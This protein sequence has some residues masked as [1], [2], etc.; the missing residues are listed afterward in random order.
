MTQTELPPRDLAMSL[1]AVYAC[2]FAN[3]LGMGL[4]LPLFSLLLERNGRLQRRFPANARA[5]WLE[6]H[7]TPEGEITVDDGAAKAL[8]GGASLLAVG[9]RAVTGPFERGAAVAIRD[10][11]GRTIAKGVTAY[12][13]ADIQRIAGRRTEEAEALLGYR[14]RPAIIHRDDM[15]RL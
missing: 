15:V 5:A 7:L 8:A 3:G 12:S 10:A 11:S 1:G 14:G 9:V 6:G 13:S 4:S 2:I